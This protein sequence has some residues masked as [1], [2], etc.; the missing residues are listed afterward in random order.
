MEF[1]SWEYEITNNLGKVLESHKIPIG[2][3][4]HQPLYTSSSELFPSVHHW[5]MVYSAGPLL[6]H[7]IW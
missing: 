6:G 3:S 7:G 2:S 5:A 4:H 1:V